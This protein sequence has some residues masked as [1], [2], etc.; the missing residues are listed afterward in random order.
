MMDAKQLHLTEAVGERLA[1]LGWAGDDPRVRDA[2]P[3][4]ARGHNLAV[5]APPAPAYGAPALAGLVS[6]LAANPPDGPALLL[7][8]EAELDVWSGLLSALLRGT[9]LRLEVA[10][11]AARGARRLGSGA[12]CLLVAPPEALSALT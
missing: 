6:R 4:A 3:T 8:P 12:L 10:R 2:A 11:G 9:D 1:A 7:C 5:V